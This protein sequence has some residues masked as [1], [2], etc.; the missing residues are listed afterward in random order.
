MTKGRVTF[1]DHT[2]KIQLFDLTDESTYYL[3]YLLYKI[4]TNIM[5]YIFSLDISLQVE[6]VLGRG[7]LPVL[8]WSVFPSSLNKLLEQPVT[9]KKHWFV[10]VRSHR[11]LSSDG[12]SDDFTHSKSS[13]QKW[14]GL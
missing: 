13:L 2:T 10:L 14:V 4:S 1:Y 11:E 3:V 9:A 8:V 12:I 7:T 5:R 6:C